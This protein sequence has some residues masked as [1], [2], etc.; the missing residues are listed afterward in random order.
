MRRRA[1]K[2]RLAPYPWLRAPFAGPRIISQ[3]TDALEPPPACSS[4]EVS[5]PQPSTDPS[6][7]G[8]L[9]WESS[10]SLGIDSTS[11]PV[12]VSMRVENPGSPA[13]P[14]LGSPFV[15]RQ[16]VPPGRPDSARPAPDS[17]AHITAA[18]S[19]PRRG[20]EGRA[21][22]PNFLQPPPFAEISLP[23]PIRGFP[24]IHRS[25]PRSLTRN[26]DPLQL[27]D[28]LDRRASASVGVQ[29]YGVGYPSLETAK[30]VTD[31]LRDALIALTKCY[32]I[33]VAAPIAA[34]DDHGDHLV[35]L[36][37]VFLAYNMTEGVATRLKGQVCWSVDDISFFAYDLLPTIPTLLFTLRG[38]TRHDTATIQ[39]IVRR[40]MFGPEYT[41]FTASFASDN[42]RFRGLSPDDIAEVLLQSLKVTVTES[43]APSGMVT[44]NVYCDPPTTSPERWTL[45]RNTLGAAEYGHN[46]IGIGSRVEDLAC[47]GCHGADHGVDDCP[48]K[49]I[50]GWNS[51]H[52]LR[53]SE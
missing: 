53:D 41:L 33:E 25:H 34:K 15:E 31:A 39:E 37:S 45:W 47:T 46:F 49:R 7:S 17:P 43:G 38:F 2:R 9:F 1:A 26:L 27:L 6:N 35:P 28:W 5:V 12:D 11:S 8:T 32:T 29:V 21:T 44:V 42:P 18:T 23:T 22:P 10:D 24:S 40:T 50:L 30:A 3:T 36:P 20:D 52:A 14:V 51:E 48:F 16:P 13:I 19:L 4:D